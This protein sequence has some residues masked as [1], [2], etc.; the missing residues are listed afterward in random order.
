MKRTTALI[1]TL[2]AFGLAG[3]ADTAVGQHQTAVEQLSQNKARTGHVTYNSFFQQGQAR[4][5]SA[6]EELQIQSSAR[7]TSTPSSTDDLAI[8]L[9]APAVNTTPA[10][11]SPRV[12]TPTIS[13]DNPAPPATKRPATVPD[14]PMLDPTP[15]GVSGYAPTVTPSQGTNAGCD[16]PISIGNPYLDGSVDC[17]SGAGCSPQ[18]ER[19]FQRPYVNRRPREYGGN[20]MADGNTGCAD[21]MDSL[22]DRLTGKVNQG[23]LT[24]DED[25][26]CDGPSPLYFGRYDALLGLPYASDTH[27]GALVRDGSYSRAEPFDYDLVFASRFT[28]GFES[29]KGP[30]GM[31][32]YF[33]LNA[34]SNPLAISPATG[35]TTIQGVMNL[36][37]AT[38]INNSLLGGR[39]DAGAD[40]E[41]SSIRVEAFKRIYWP[42]STL[43]GGFGLNYSNIDQNVYYANFSSP[44]STTASGTLLG[45]RGFEGLGPTFSL[46]YYR[47]I[48]HTHIAAIGGIYSGILFGSDDWSVSRNGGLLYENHSTR[49]MTQV[50]V[51]LGAEYSRSFGCNNDHRWFVRTT[52]EAQNWLN[53]GSFQSVNSDFGFASGNFSI[54]VSY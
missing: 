42:V 25:C 36:P 12:S 10:I 48:G 29:T 13:F 31:L 33:H 20:L 3:Q 53:M 17:N 35:T 15:M 39:M 16:A 26:G 28:A 7:S 27:P 50:N 18:S 6:S 1:L 52:V 22:Y 21:P 4:L 34:N 46:N 8:S 43:S 51:H 14:Q 37:S 19:M 44:T 49:V 54:G 40:Q 11:R 41:I 2:A 23:A 32:E 38:I 47:P 45:E 30:G 5:A 24:L 9:D